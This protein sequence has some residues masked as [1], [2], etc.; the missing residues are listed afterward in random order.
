MTAIAI[1]TTV[2]AALILAM[3][4]ASIYRDGNGGD[5]ERE[6]DRDARL[7]GALPL[8]PEREDLTEELPKPEAKRI[9]GT[10]MVSMLAET[11]PETPVTVI[12]HLGGPAF[13]VGRPPEDLLERIIAGLRPV[14]AELV[15]AEAQ[16]RSVVKARRGGV[17]QP[18]HA[19]NGPVTQQFD[20]IVAEE[21]WVTV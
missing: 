18:R 15:L 13:T 17:Y 8:A 11:E 14:P 16:R 2:A 3:I 20:A 4:V 21:G 12:E 9:P 6:S 19:D 10:H 1:A 7:A 5:I